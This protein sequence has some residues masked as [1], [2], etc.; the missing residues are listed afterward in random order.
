MN[1]EL[2]FPREDLQSGLC[3]SKADSFHTSFVNDKVGMI[4]GDR[5]V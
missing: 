4:E 3:D 5:D 2:Q 1:L